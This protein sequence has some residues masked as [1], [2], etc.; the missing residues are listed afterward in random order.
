MWNAYVPVLSTHLSMTLTI[1]PRG[2]EG[3]VSLLCTDASKAKADLGHVVTDL[4]PC[5][6]K[7]YIADIHTRALGSPRPVARVALRVHGRLVSVSPRGYSIRVVKHPQRLASKRPVDAL[8]KRTGPFGVLHVSMPR[9]LL[10]PPRGHGHTRRRSCLC[11][12]D[13]LFALGLPSRHLD[14]VKAL[15]R[16]HQHLFSRMPNPS[17]LISRLCP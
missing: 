1:V 12:L 5:R 17:K 8:G 14:R 7:L 3:G 11:S 6:T 10:L 16:A 15:V 4:L 9:D 2:W 13:S